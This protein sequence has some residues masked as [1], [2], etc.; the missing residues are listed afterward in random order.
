MRTKTV[1]PLTS[2][3]P[4]WF[5]LP[6]LFIALSGAGF[7]L[8]RFGLHVV[9]PT[10]VSWFPP[11]GDS[12]WH[13]LVWHFF[14]REPWGLPPGQVEGFMAPMG[15]S[16]G[17]AD[18]LPLL[19]FPLKLLSGVLPP[20]VQYLGPWLLISYTLQGVFGY[21]LARTFCGSRWL[22][23]LAGLFF[24]F[25]PVMVFRAG[26]IALAS[27]W[28]LLFALWHYF[29]TAKRPD[30]RLRTYAGLWLLITALVGLIH[31]YLAAMVFPVALVSMWREW[32]F[33]ERLALRSAATLIGAMGALLALEWWLSG[34][35]GT[36]QSLRLWGFD[37]YSM[38]LN[39]LFNP[40]TRSR[41]LPPL[42]LGE[43]QYEGF[44]YLG[45]G[46]LLLGGLALALSISRSTKAAR[47][48]LTR[49]RAAGHLPLALL[50]LGFSLYALGKTVTL[51][52][53][54]LFELPL[55]TPFPALT[56]TFRASGRFVW[57]AYYLLYLL[58]LAYLV[59]RLPLGRAALVLGAGFVIQL[60][61]LDI[62]TPFQADQ[63]TFSAN[64]SDERWTQLVAPFRT[65]A[66]IPAFA[67]TTAN[68]GDYADF[69][70]L[71]ANQ[72]KAVTTGAAARPP[73]GL[74]AV[75]E[76][77]QDEAVMGPRDPETLYVFGAVRFATSYLT[78]L[79]PGLHCHALDD[80]VAC[81]SGE[82]NLELGP[83]LDLSRYTPSGY[84][85]VT[86][87][88]YLERYEDQTVVIVAREGVGETLGAA[89]ELL[90]EQ[91]LQI[92][93]VAPEGSYAAV[94]HQGRVVFEGTS[95]EEAVHQ[96]WAKGTI[97]GDGAAELTLPKH[98]RILSESTPE[99]QQAQLLVGGEPA[100]QPD[101]G[102]N[103]AVLDE[104]FNVVSAANFDTFVT[105]VA[106]VAE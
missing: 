92:D 32:R 58:I 38:N 60:V 99:A 22:A 8:Y 106:V 66:V 23:L 79:A 83:K 72:G 77:L 71:A 47:R 53:V 4:R 26:H 64:L 18:A 101:R 2:A 67:R 88:D 80:Y 43:G 49:L 51:G 61:D 100:L 28:V 68:R 90:T 1:R 13:F 73:V 97:I 16:I 103:V 56:G 29:A 55:F 14:R 63:P 6:L 36:E 93:Q 31:P 40:L 19:A 78:K 84:A 69:T 20:N 65:I 70:Y 11:L 76:Q 89:A 52:D 25:S 10:N 94:L 12:T 87:A 50:A 82:R 104:G 46:M 7:A 96:R 54:A 30:F 102:L 39:A 41:V 17:S 105:D 33:G 98:L 42:P 37:H 3:A 24:L 48:P 27:H 21:L 9:D 5:S 15:T 45:L 57:L 95:Q 62:N 86:L 74:E 81:Y 91:G 75:K 44:A 85:R 34:L 35:I 59:K